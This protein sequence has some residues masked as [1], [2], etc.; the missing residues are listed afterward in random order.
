MYR[1]FCHSLYYTHSHLWPKKKRQKET[2]AIITVFEHF[3]KI[4]I[5]RHHNLKEYLPCWRIASLA[6]MRLWVPFQTVWYFGRAL[7]RESEYD[8]TI[9]IRARERRVGRAKSLS[10]ESSILFDTDRTSICSRQQD[11]KEGLDREATV[12]EKG[13]K[14]FFSEPLLWLCCQWAV[15]ERRRSCW[16][17]IWQP[18]RQ[19]WPWNTMTVALPLVL[20][21]SCAIFWQFLANFAPT[22]RSED[23]NT[24][25]YD[26][27]C[28]GHE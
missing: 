16:E 5:F 15:L 10:L 17:T 7:C 11:R 26:K 1:A 25:K 4:L 28:I 12:N 18:R 13:D 9:S 19:T 24:H 6:K 23:S 27:K 3:H 22:I 21:R 14:D 8:I 2:L 20:T